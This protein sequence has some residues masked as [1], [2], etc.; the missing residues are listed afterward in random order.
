MRNPG[1][2]RW[3]E[4]LTVTQ[5]TCQ[6]WNQVLWLQVFCPFL[7]PSAV[8]YNPRHPQPL[9]L[10]YRETLFGRL[11]WSLYF[12]PHCWMPSAPPHLLQVPLLPFYGGLFQV[13]RALT[14][15]LW[16]RTLWFCISPSTM[17][18][19]SLFS[20]TC[21]YLLTLFFLTHVRWYFIMVLICII[22]R[23]VMLV[24]FSH[25]CCPFLW[26]LWKNVYLGSLPF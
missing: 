16:Y 8:R 14:L 21:Q 9:F 23:L 15:P 7:L 6:D 17:L 2:D 25:T 18:K 22:L 24:T 4:Q 13:V 5:Q 19:C 10:P 12:L 11:S 20:E 1:S 3:R 26:F